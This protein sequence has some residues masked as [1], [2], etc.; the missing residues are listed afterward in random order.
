MTTSFNAVSCLCFA[1]PALPHV[2]S[3][4]AP[5][6]L[7]EVPSFL[8]HQSLSLLDGS[9]MR[10]SPMKCFPRMIA[11]TSWRARQHEALAQISS[12]ARTVMSWS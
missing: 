6:P 5:Q 9:G 11:G 2:S 8:T 4:N 12:F 7:V 3:G 1:T 10:G